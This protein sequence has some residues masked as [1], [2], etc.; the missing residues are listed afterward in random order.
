M[1]NDSTRL[2]QINATEGSKQT[3]AS[4]LQWQERTIEE[5][6]KAI[7]LQEQMVVSILAAAWRPDADVWDKGVLKSL[8]ASFSR[9]VNTVIEHKIADAIALTDAGTPAVEAFLTTGAIG[10]LTHK[11][12]RIAVEKRQLSQFFNCWQKQSLVPTELIP[13]E[14]TFTS[15]LIRLGI[16]GMVI[17]NVFMFVMLFIIPELQK[18]FEEFGIEM[19]PAS[20]SMMYFGY[21]TAKLW[22]IPALVM[23]V[24]TV[25]FFRS[26][27]FS[28][29]ASR[30]SPRLWTATNWMPED[31]KRLTTAWRLRPSGTRL[32]AGSEGPAAAVKTSAA[33]SATAA[34][35]DSW[36][37]PNSY[38][39]VLSKSEL[40][41]L[42]STND[43]ELKDWL[44][45]KMI[46]AKR[47]RR[48]RRSS[49]WATI[50]LGAGHCFLGGIVILVALSV[51]GSL[52]AI[53]EGLTGGRP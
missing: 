29:W 25:L 46:H 43:E 51:F 4:A 22:F 36:E 49:G 3:Q 17:F 33:T 31:Q 35:S 9:D 45:E 23:L 50:F 47:E 27:G 15:K 52:L 42:S 53:I 39:N 37:R 13:H 21:M 48:N 19:T 1:S 11:A 26:A 24:L 32:V 10:P 34:T 38:E 20:R 12:L 28:E 40:A 14:R 2:P 18:M 30:W 44:F 7:P 16:T 6:S 8:L 5:L 41:A